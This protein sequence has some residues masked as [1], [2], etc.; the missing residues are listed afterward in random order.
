MHSIQLT[1]LCLNGTGKSPSTADV[2]GCIMRDSCVDA[3][4]GA[5]FSS[6]FNSQIT[7]FLPLHHKHA[8][9]TQQ[10]VFGRRSGM[11]L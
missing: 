9:R 10:W 4:S 7:I 3:S 1:L 8:F 6:F 11:L 5:A 2:L